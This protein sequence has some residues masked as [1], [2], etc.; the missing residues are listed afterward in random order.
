MLRVPAHLGRR[1][2]L[3]LVADAGNR[4][5]VVV[6]QG[7]VHLGVGVHRHVGR[8]RRRRRPLGLL[9]L[10]PRASVLL[11]LLILLGH[12]VLRLRLRRRGRRL[13]RLLGR[14]RGL[15][16]GVHPVQIPS[17]L[18]A[19]GVRS[20]QGLLQYQS[21]ATTFAVLRHRRCHVGMLDGLVAVGLAEV[22]GPV[23]RLGCQLGLGGVVLRRSDHVLLLDV[24]LLV[25]LLGLRLL[26]DGLR[27]RLG[28][29][30]GLVLGRRDGGAK[31]SAAIV[32]V[33][34]D[35]SLGVGL[36]PDLP[37]RRPFVA[38]PHLP[39]HVGM[40]VMCVR[41]VVGI[42]GAVVLRWG[43]RLG[44]GGGGPF[45]TSRGPGGGAHAV[46]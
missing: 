44:G 36:R 29:R 16:P 40:R 2:M 38:A 4:G 46:R 27:L 5:G 28:L 45:G 8:R 39:A 17:P 30:L 35:D 21:R 6:Q 41:C 26:L 32:I 43:W 15:R 9:L 23:G 31:G 11:V 34:L 14:L 10:S 25:S 12:G 33:P 24:L 7:G 3:G 19:R 18:G 13:P 37:G 20:A 42:V 22:V 1:H